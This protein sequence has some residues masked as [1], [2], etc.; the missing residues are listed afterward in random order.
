MNLKLRTKL[1]ELNVQLT[2][3]L[4]KVQK[5]SLSPVRKVT[6]PNQGQPD[7]GHQIRA[8]EHELSNV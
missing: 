6:G 5:G 8:K 2:R 7:V 3:S 1:K 4:D